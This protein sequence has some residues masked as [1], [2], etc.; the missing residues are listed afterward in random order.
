MTASKLSWTSNSQK[1]NIVNP[2]YLH[3][4]HF[5]GSQT[6]ARPAFPPRKTL[7][8]THHT[9]GHHNGLSHRRCRNQHCTSV[10]IVFCPLQHLCPFV[11]RDKGNSHMFEL[12][13]PSSCSSLPLY[14]SHP[15]PH[16]QAAF[17][18][19]GSPGVRPLTLLQGHKH[20]QTIRSP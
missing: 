17:P 2:G 3:H 20:G 8:L 11:P 14:A 12:Q 1:G 10:T 13:A 9:L 5:A 6:H 15:P 16:H 18:P 7:R 4:F 19:V